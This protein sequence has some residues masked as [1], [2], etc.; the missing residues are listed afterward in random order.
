MAAK[1][2]YA[3]RDGLPFRN[4]QVVGSNPT[5]GSLILNELR[6]FDLIEIVCPCI[7]CAFPKVNVRF[8]ELRPCTGKPDFRAS[9]GGHCHRVAGGVA[10]V[11]P[12]KQSQ[13]TP[14]SQFRHPSAPFAPEFR[15]RDSR[16]GRRC[17]RI[18]RSGCA[19]CLAVSGE[20]ARLRFVINETNK[21]HE[22]NR[23]IARA[24]SFNVPFFQL[25]DTR[26]RDETL[27]WVVIFAANWSMGA[28]TIQ[29]S[30]Q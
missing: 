7:L 23:S 19:I 27:G 29:E 20:A 6:L 10:R 8:H 30:R 16:R 24:H 22:N 21:H 15:S 26:G 1:I 3:R 9:S 4:E 2:L 25:H 13:G 11:H 28:A 5:S 12:S 14:G 18:H 17:A